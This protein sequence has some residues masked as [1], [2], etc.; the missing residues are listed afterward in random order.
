VIRSPRNLRSPAHLTL[1][2]GLTLL[3][4]L[5]AC[6][7]PS[8]DR[9][10]MDTR[11][12]TDSSAIAS[13]G[14]ARAGP[15]CP[16]GATYVLGDT[17]DWATMIEEGKRAVLR[18]GTTVIDTVDVLFGVHAVGRDS[19]VFLPVLAYEVDSA[20]AA[21]MPGPA[22]FP[23]EH[24][25]CTPSGRRVLSSS[26]PHF[27][28]GFSSPSVI[29]STLYY[30]GLNLQDDRGRYRLY[31]MRYTARDGRVDSLFLREETPVMDF[32]YFYGPPFEQAGA[33]VF[34]G[35]EAR[36]IVDPRAW[37]VVRVERHAPAA[38]ERSSRSAP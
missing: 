36:A 35:G 27:N 5:A 13:A 29:D 28:S 6:A 22:A 20:E 25:L 1:H 34:E 14:A 26:L 4:G 10:E 38:G 33:I 24:V 7:K 18:A 11:A 31:A 16:A 15:P 3:L 21:M 17:S 9:T 30:W 32:R 37:R 12:R 8:D 23:E 19:L 2:I